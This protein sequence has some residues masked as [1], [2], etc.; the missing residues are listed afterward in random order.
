[1]TSSK[2]AAIQAYKERKAP[3]G[4]FAIRCAA[5]GTVWVDSAL[6]LDTAENRTWFFL[7]NRD[8]QID[9]SVLAEFEAHG[10]ESF[11]FEIL[12]KLDD[13]VVPLALKGL[14]KERKLHWL[15]QLNAR[16]LTPV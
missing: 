15:A 9:R 13:D 10:R 4:I 1:M 3:R 12:E 6:D 11:S 2:K 14:L 5:T 7:K 16:K 8:T